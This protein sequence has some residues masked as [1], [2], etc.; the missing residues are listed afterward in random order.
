MRSTVGAGVIRRELIELCSEGRVK[1]AHA[2][3][4]ASGFDAADHPSLWEFL[5]RH[6]VESGKAEIGHHLRRD[7]LAADVA[8]TEIVLNEAR[9]EIERGQQSTARAFLERTF[10]P[11]PEIAEAR[12]LL[13][14]ALATEDRDRALELLKEI[15]GG[16]EADM[17]SAIDALRS[18]GELQRAIRLCAAALDRYPQNA[19]F[20]N[21]LG[22]LAEGVRDFETAV[23]TAK[24]QLDRDAETAAQALNRLVRL[25]RRLGHYEEATGYAADL[26]RRDIG[27]L[28]KLRLARE[29]RQLR[30]TEAIV[31]TLPHHFRTGRLAPEEA[32][33]AVSF[34]IEEGQ[35]GLAL[36]LWRSGLPMRPEEQHLLERRG[37]ARGRP[38][39][40][41][42]ARQIKSP[43]VLLPLSPDRDRNPFPAGW[44][45]ALM[46]S[47]PILLVN[48]VLAAG[49][50]ER[51]F[52]MVARA[53]VDA[54]R[55]PDS[56]HAALFSIEADRGHDHFA[57]ALRATGIHVHDLSQR[58]LSQMDL[59]ER[60]GDA[61]ALFPARLRTDV[62]ALHSLARELNPA[63]IHGWQDRAAVAAGLVAQ[64][65]GTP[66]TVLSMRNMRP[67]K[68]GET[69]DWISQPVYRAILADPSVRI[70]ANAA[71]AARDYENWLALY[72]GTVS[73][74]ANAVDHAI[75]SPR[76]QPRPAHPAARI[77]GVFR[78]TENKR[79]LLWLE[80]VAALQAEHG[81]KIAPR[82]L[83]AGPMAEQVRQKAAAL[84]LDQL[85]LEAPVSDPSAVY[86][87]S[88]ALLL[89]SSV[90]GTPN[91][92]LEAQACGLPVAACRVGGV[93]E[94]LYVGRP[95]GG[96]LLDAEITA[97]D[98][99][100]RIA[101]WLPGVRDAADAAR[102]A[103]IQ[104][105]Y[106]T[107][108]L[109]RTLL[110]LYG[111]PS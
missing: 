50:A 23:K 75:F 62:L 102:I 98:A 26:L 109:A 15:D 61:L 67:Q 31:A 73:I 68:R 104:D 38:K 99:A 44:L 29:L 18:L 42:D 27:P 85:Q 78:L 70:T 72:E 11:T 54:G 41:E 63:V 79:P 101:A 43:D 5:E 105:R 48:S 103:F 19:T 97:R 52:L 8:S 83:G 58:N 81:I 14:A 30:L 39:S 4:M 34:L 76:P 107:Q 40:I 1:A 92:I 3:L 49:G 24:S 69:A 66:R 95:G 36:F 91:V 51:Q 37:F 33:R 88:D 53:L 9:Y 80:T 2:R 60:E 94:A 86:R 89:M 32:T 13:G 35:L 77:L 59:T 17:L 74:L 28:P 111:A 64:M 10:G 12:I 20:A 57:D 90:E 25:S 87:D 16:S 100:S 6:A 84:G 108:A 22:W 45:P 110:S 71:E 96:L 55:S 65:L 21:R 82:I 46:E 47:D 7:L 93:A 56:V 106:S